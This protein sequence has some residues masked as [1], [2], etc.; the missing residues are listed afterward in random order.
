M[1][2]GLPFGRGIQVGRLFGVHILL[3]WSL[4]IIFG[5][6]TFSLATAVFPQ[7]HPDWSPALVWALSLAAALLFFASVLAHELC[8]ALV[9][10]ARGIPVPRITLF[11]FGGA[12]QMA[13]EPRS[14]KDEFLIAIV[15][16]LASAG[17][18]LTAWVLGSRLAFPAEV[19][20]EQL[21]DPAELMSHAG[22]LAT[23]LL[24]LGPVNIILAV[25]NLIPGFP[26]DGGRVLRSILWWSSG[27]LVR[28]TRWASRGGQWFAWVLMGIGVW[29]LL[30]G[31]FGQGM[32]LL[33]IGWFLNNAARM[34]YDRLMVGQALAGV[35]VA[36][37]MVTDLR[38]LPP[39][40]DGMRLADQLLASDQRAYPVAAADGRLLGLVCL[41]D[42]RRVPRDHWPALRVD[43]IMTPVAK[44]HALTPDAA[45]ER[46]L[47]LMAH[48]D[49]D[50]IPIMRGDALVGLVRRRDIV[51]WLALAGREAVPRFAH[52]H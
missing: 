41:D 21:A 51:K 3:D 29:S 42:L 39:D 6:V 26:L 12:A 45:A 32:W 2:A 31:G 28:A 49:I 27:D 20:A 17:I 30:A 48:H 43:A 34:S 22:P 38:Q 52:A 23:L 25:F 46:A 19:A 10:K 24:W 18:G 8:H 36:D 11:L 50:Q 9:A 5:L 33:L 7:W 40:L 16:P 47:E 44:L 4:L 13:G 14:P 35:P 1:R 37:L 15:G